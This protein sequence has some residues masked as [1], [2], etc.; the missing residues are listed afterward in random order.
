MSGFDVHVGTGGF[1]ILAREISGVGNMAAI[2]TFEAFGSSRRSVDRANGVIRDVKIIGFHSRNRRTYSPESLKSALAKYEGV[3]VNVDH[4]PASNPTLPRSVADRIGVLKNVRFVEGSGIHGDFHFN[5]KHALA[6]QIAWDA[7]H[8]PSA[9]GFSHNARVSMGRGGT[10]ESVERVVSVDLVADPATTNGVFESATDRRRQDS[11]QDRTAED[12]R[13]KV[14]GRPTASEQ[15][16]Q[17]Q[18]SD[19]WRKRVLGR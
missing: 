17:N 2:Q 9:I 3:K 5:P 4:P 15:W 8:N 19:E 10:V 11:L 16:E 1:R 14:L 13:H 6:E 7:E 12:W 18:L